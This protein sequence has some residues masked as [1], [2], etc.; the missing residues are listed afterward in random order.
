MKMTGRTRACLVVLSVTLLWRMLGAPLSAEEWNGVKT[1]WWQARTLLSTRMGRALLAW[2]LTVPAAQAEEL[3]PLHP[4]ADIAE[5]EAAQRDEPVLAVYDADAGLLRQV[6]LEQYVCCVVAAEMPAS[7]HLEALKAQ[8]VAART[9]ALK[10]W[11]TGGCSAHPGANICTDSGHCQAFA[12]STACRE[13]WGDSYDSYESRIVSAVKETRGL[14][15]TYES[16]PITVLYHAISGGQTEDAQAVFSAAEPYLVGVSSAGEEGASGY[17]TDTTFTRAEAAQ[18]LNATFGTALS[19]EDLDSQLSI[20]QYSASGRAKT[21]F[22]GN[23]EVSG[24]ALRHALGLRS[25]WLELLFASDT[26]TFRQRGYGHGV[27]MSQA[28]ANAMAA[29]GQGYTEILM[30]YYVGTEVVDGQELWR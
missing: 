2:P 16:E 12:T 15:L 3:L 1:Q 8:A 14:V 17:I 19:A 5:L 6:P 9:R 7:Y 26:V 23:T 18:K 11:Q 27:G 4:D 21:L 20:H 30:H 13:R 25:T 22:L 10:Q 29:Q 28:G 24:V